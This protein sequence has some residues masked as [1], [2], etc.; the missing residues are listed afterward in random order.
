MIRPSLKSE[1]DESEDMDIDLPCKRH[2]IIC[3]RTDHAITSHLSLRIRPSA[4]EHP[5]RE[6]SHT[7]YLQR[8]IPLP[9]NHTRKHRRHT[10]EAAQNDVHR[11]ADAVRE[12]PVVQH[13]DAEVQRGDEGPFAERYFRW[14]KI[15]R[16]RRRELAHVRRRG[17][18]DELEEGD[19]EATATL[20]PVGCE[21]FL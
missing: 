8:T 18:E 21:L 7:E 11:H 9:S 13:I 17:R 19:E 15:V 12:G 6:Q 5:S 10:A 16:I 4:N 2:I 3:S 14:P 1:P 20:A